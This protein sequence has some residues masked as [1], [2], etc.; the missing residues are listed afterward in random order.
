MRD[1]VTAARKLV[2]LLKSKFSQECIASESG[3]ES[4]VR[5]ISFA[6]A[7][8]ENLDSK[9]LHQMVENMENYI[10]SND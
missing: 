5:V 6:D 2:E 8:I 1:E 10:G 4:L 3:W 9:T 7:A